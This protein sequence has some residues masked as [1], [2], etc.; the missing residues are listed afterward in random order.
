MAL[1]IGVVTDI[2]CGPDMDTR[3]GTKALGLLE[4]FAREMKERFKPDI[5]VD[6]GDRINDVSVE[7]DLRRIQEVETCLRSVGVPVLSIYGNYDLV[8]VP[9][10]KQASTRGKRSGVESVDFHGFHL[11]LLNSQDPTFGGVGGTLSQPQLSWL[12]EDLKRTTQPTLVFCHH[13][14]DE[15]D[16]YF[17]WYFRS[18]PDFA[19]AVNRGR[20]RELFSQSGKVLAAFHGHM[21]WNHTSIIDGVT[22]V[23]MG[24]LSC[25]GSYRRPAGW[26]LF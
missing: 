19:L 3:L 17:H 18:R 10:G 26:V 2:H 14:L 11:V 5:I 24:A 9:M 20:A 1:E 8:N 25:C 13:P 4:G 12:E 6:M 23:T 21:H 16:S 22:Y 7:D 15:Q